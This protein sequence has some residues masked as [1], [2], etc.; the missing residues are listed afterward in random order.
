M[1]LSMRKW[2]KIKLN[3]VRILYYEYLPIWEIYAVILRYTETFW[4]GCRSAAYLAFSSFT[5]TE[6]HTL[7]QGYHKCPSNAKESVYKAAFFFSMDKSSDACYVYQITNTAYC[8]SFDF[9][10]HQHIYMHFSALQC[11]CFPLTSSG[12]LFDY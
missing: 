5:P 4:H 6:I 10:S 11:L 2:E 9:F 7:S 1:F 3:V 8:S 12:R